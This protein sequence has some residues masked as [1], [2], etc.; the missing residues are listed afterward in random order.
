MWWTKTLV[1]VYCKLMVVA[2]SWIKLDS[3]VKVIGTL[4]L[5]LLVI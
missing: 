2:L 3:S 1:N 4:R 5:D